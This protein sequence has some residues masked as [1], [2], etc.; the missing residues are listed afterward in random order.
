MGYSL[1]ASV[2]PTVAVRN[3]M[4]RR[5]TLFWFPHNLKLRGFGPLVNYSRG[6]YSWDLWSQVVFF[7]QWNALEKENA[8]DRSDNSVGFLWGLRC[9]SLT[10]GSLV[11]RKNH[12]ANIYPTRDCLK[13]ILFAFQYLQ[14]FIFACDIW[15]S[16]LHCCFC[17][18]SI[19]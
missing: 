2:P 17:S 12:W 16:N 3:L 9:K 18:F 8:L 10:W 4:R 19:F 6:S 13:N 11:S 7:V 1:I 5:K 14:A 15:V